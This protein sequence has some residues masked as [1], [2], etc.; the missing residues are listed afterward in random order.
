MATPIASGGMLKGVGRYGFLSLGAIFKFLRKHWYLT[1]FLIIIFPAVIDS[2]QVAIETQNPLH[3][4]LQLAKRIFVADML[5]IDYLASSLL[6]LLFAVSF[7]LVCQTF[8]IV[9]SE[10]RD[11]FIL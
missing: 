8:S 11:P 7:L 10:T 9:P 3:P 2:V 4:L 1:I 6:V 5:S